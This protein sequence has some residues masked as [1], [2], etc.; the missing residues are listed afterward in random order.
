M[1]RK[2]KFITPPSNAFQAPF[3]WVSTLIVRALVHTPITPNQVTLMRALLAIFALYCFALGSAPFLIGGVVTFYV[4]EVLDHVDGDLARA[5]NCS[6]HS[7]YL[8]EQ[9]VD[10]WAS[11]PS[12]IFGFCVALGMYNESA[13]AVGF[14]LFSAT[15][16]GRLMW[17]E[18]R[19]VFGWDRS[20]G[21]GV[22]QYQPLISTS[23]TR[24]ARNIAEL[25]Y[26]WNN[27]FILVGMIL[28]VPGRQ[29][30]SIDTLEIGFLCV[31]IVNN[32]PW[33]AI[34]VRGFV[35][36]IHRKGTKVSFPE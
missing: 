2:F 8:Y 29:Y 22:D 25:A 14:I 7:G 4:F 12:N 31:A 5:K 23:V 24:T 15:V 17:L 33:M 34:V 20:S 36:S 19:T 21:D 35:K 13:S 27:Q 30:F 10:T 9:F 6:S 11:R 26:T 28:I 32:I 18:F 16:F 1:F 3:R